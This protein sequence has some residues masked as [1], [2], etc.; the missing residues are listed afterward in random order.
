METVTQIKD[1]LLLPE[2]APHTTKGMFPRQ[3]RGYSFGEGRVLSQHYQSVRR[4]QVIG[5]AVLFPP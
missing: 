3:I 2:E 4:D 1:V 5:P